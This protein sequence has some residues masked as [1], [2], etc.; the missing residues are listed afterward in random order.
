MPVGKLKRAALPEPSAKPPVPAWPAKVV[1]VPPDVIL[2]MT[3]LP[4]SATYTLPAA[5][6]ARLFGAWNWVDVPEPSA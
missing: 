1:T 6:T 2:R 3:L 4:E 5:S